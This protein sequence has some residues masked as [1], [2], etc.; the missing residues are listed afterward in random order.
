MATN[1][2]EHVIDLAPAGASIG[3]GAPRSR[4]V[5]VALAVVATLAAAVLVLVP[6]GDPEVA[7]D[8]D[9]TTT[10]T[11]FP[12]P[13]ALGAPDD[14]K[15]SVGLPV[16]AEPATGLVDGQT[17]QVTGTGFP[18]GESIG[19]VMCTKEAGQD[20]GARGVDACNI[21]RFAQTTA[22]ADGVATVPFEVRRLVL[23]DGQEVDCASE[24]QRCLIGMGMIS[25]YDR[26]GGVLVDFD[27]TA[28]LPDPPAA[29]IEDEGPFDDGETVTVRVDGL[30][31]GTGVG[32]ALCTEDGSRC[33]DSASD[34]MVGDDGSATFDL[35]LWRVFSAPVWDATSVGDDV[36]CATMACR[37]QVWGEPV[38]G[39]AIPM[40]ELGFTDG[41][42]E[43]TRPVLEVRSVGPYRPGDQ[44]EAFVPDVGRNGGLD[45]LL[46]NPETCAG[47]MAELD[48]V[49]G[50]IQARLTVPSAAEG[51]PCIGVP[52]RL[53]AHVWAEPT[54]EAAP[55]LAPAPV[56][57]VI[58][59]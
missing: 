46:C 10:T 34:A 39:R 54:P 12:A 20:H 28:P 8:E 32:A 2:A 37:L 22:D 15:D 14:G 35:R 44:I 55:P 16:R 26:S 57:V 24:A 49:F 31:P 52:C 43:R 40:I 56:E 11:T 17:V 59:P 9:A 47:G 38:G 18:P 53:V 51:N 6:S 4:A 42:I 3:A 48:W 58:E 23:L 19:V 7:V 25:D 41:P 21:G 33:A 27:P 29:T 1:D 30:R 5:L 36:D 50:G 45:L 13:L